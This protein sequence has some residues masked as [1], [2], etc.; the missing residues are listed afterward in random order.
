MRETLLHLVKR[1]F[2]LS[3]LGGLLLVLLAK[4]ELIRKQGMCV[5]VPRRALSRRMYLQSPLRICSCSGLFCLQSLGHTCVLLSLE[6]RHVIKSR[7][8]FKNLVA[9]QNMP[10]RILRL[11][12]KTSFLA[13]LSKGYQSIQV[14]LQLDVDFALACN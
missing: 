4:L 9:K 6:A 7:Q 14:H 13:R 1:L 2:E 12:R 11:Y 10:Q 8:K 5:S 3:S